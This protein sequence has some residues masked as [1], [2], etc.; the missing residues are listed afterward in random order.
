MTTL[1]TNVTRPYLRYTS[2][3]FRTAERHGYFIFYYA[4]HSFSMRRKRGKGM[5]FFWDKATAL[6]RSASSTF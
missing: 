5:Y 1:L 4:P 3:R 2:S 6:N